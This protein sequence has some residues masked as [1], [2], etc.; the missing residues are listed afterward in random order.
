MSSDNALAEID[1]NG[2]IEEA[3]AEA[4]ES[5][6]SGDTRLSFLKKGRPCRETGFLV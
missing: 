5:L 1:A 6:Q 4:S 3:A 2:R